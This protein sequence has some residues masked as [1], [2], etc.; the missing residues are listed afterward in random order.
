MKKSVLA[1]FIII[2]AILFSQCATGPNEVPKNINREFYDEVPEGKTPEAERDSEKKE[3]L[4]DSGYAKDDG[5]L[6]ATRIP[7]ELRSAE[8]PLPSFG[9][10]FEETFIEDTEAPAISRTSAAK[11]TSSGLKAGFEDDNRQ[12]NYFVNF[13]EEFKHV[14]HFNLPVNERI[15]IKVKDSLM[16][17]VPNA[18]ISIYDGDKELVKG[19]THADGGYQFNPSEF[20]RDINQYLVKINAENMPEKTITLDRFGEREINLAYDKPRTIKEPIPLDIVFIMDTTGSMGEEI[21]RLKLTIEL[22]HMNL[23]S[24]PNDLIIR[25]GMVMYKDRNDIYLTE[26]IPLTADLEKFQEELNKVTAEGGGDM[27]EDLQYALQDTLQ[28]IDWNLSASGIRLAFIIT[29]APPH[30]DY[31]D[32]KYKYTD[33]VRDARGIAL[34]IHSIG[35]GGLNESGEYILRQIAQYTG[36]RYIFLTYGESGESSGGT[37]GSVSH[38]TGANYQT[39]KM[40]SIIIRFAKEEIAFLSS[41]P[42]PEDDPYLEARK[43]ED[44]EKE[45]TL[46]KLFSMSISQLIDFS[47]YKIEKTDKAAILPIV[48]ETGTQAAAEYFGQQLVMAAAK[49]NSFTLVERTDLNVIFDEM[50]LK[51]AGI[52]EG[53]GVSEIG[54]LLEASYLVSSRMY[55]KNNQYEIFLKLLRVSTGE[56]LSVTKAKL[57]KSLGL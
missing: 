4:S 7:G 32:Q 16:N 30:L 57:D 56:V 13:L 47:T 24:L 48:D 36:G 18:D 41:T 23:S 31:R 46:K 3:K 53:E 21:E 10:G 1:V 12:F 2:A 34:K 25:F 38:H 17:S 49:E 5:S 28:N 29:D 33:A 15:I 39:D 22:I 6:A 8:A 55:E 26:S 45:E 43:I 35:T 14:P 44:E 19:K 11:P 51:L 42:L 37:P 54:N 50:N 9:G 52:T 40:E 27:P 20:G